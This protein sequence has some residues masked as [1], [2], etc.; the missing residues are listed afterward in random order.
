M[1]QQTLNDSY[2]HQGLRK[3]ML[4]SLVEAGINDM[5]VL[6]V[7]EEI[8]RH[9][10]LESAF[11]DFAYGDKPFP[12]R[13]NFG[14]LPSLDIAKILS[15]FN[16]KPFQKVLEVGVGTGYHSALMHGLKAK[17]YVVESDRGLFK[18]SGIL[19]QQLGMSIKLYFQNNAL[20]GLLDHAPFEAI[21]V[22]DTVLFEPKEL[23]DQLAI[24]G[25]LIYRIKEGSDVVTK[26]VV[27]VSDVEYKTFYIM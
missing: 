25:K 27:R 2:K 13:A 5:E 1:T 11:L 17:V 20:K 8:P 9:W 23:L 19:F 14:I 7:M 6:R 15:E 16:L 26:L 12:N 18:D 4:K 22:L 3:Q 24:D 21:H 10:F